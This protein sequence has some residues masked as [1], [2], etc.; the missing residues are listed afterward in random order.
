[1]AILSCFGVLHGIVGLVFGV[2]A[3]AKQSSDPEGSRRISRIGWIVFGVLVVL[4]VI[5]AIIAVAIGV[6]NDTTSFDTGY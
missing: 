6:A 3:L 1:M 4:A 2:I 5:G